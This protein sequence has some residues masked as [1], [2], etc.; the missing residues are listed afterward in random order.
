MPSQANPQEWS[1]DQVLAQREHDEG[2]EFLIGWTP[3][4]EKSQYL[5]NFFF[6][7]TNCFIVIF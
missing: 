7:F 5:V 1:V 2:P 4:W 6:I 3:T